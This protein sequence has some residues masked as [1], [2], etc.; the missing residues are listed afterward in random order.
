MQMKTI[1]LVLICSVSVGSFAQ[2]ILKYQGFLSKVLLVESIEL[3]PD[4]TFRWTSEY[5]LSWSEFGEY[6][7]ST[8]KLI[9]N[10]SDQKSKI[11]TYFMTEAGLI[12]LD[13]KG[14]P[15]K[16]IKDKSFKTKWSWLKGHKH[17]YEIKKVPN[18]PK[19]HESSLSKSDG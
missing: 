2:D 6:E 8:D 15:V 14:K 18:K 10:F 4:G 7:M 11:E 3:Y 12:K 17:D 19:P 9:L 5:D 13:E 16:K 1:F